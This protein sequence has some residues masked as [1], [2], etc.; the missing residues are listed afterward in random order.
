MNDDVLLAARDISFRQRRR[1]LLHG[2]E[3]VV[4]RGEIVTLIG[5]NGAGKTTLIRVL[6]GLERPD[7]GT[8][9]RRAGLRAGY[10]P[11]H[12]AVDA[13][14]PVTVRRFL[15]TG[16]AGAGREAGRYLA[17][18]GAADV[19]DRPLQRLSGGELRRVLLARALVCDPDLLVLDEPV[20]GVDVS[21]QLDMY[22]LVARLRDERGLGVLIVSHDLHLVMAAT[23]HVTCLSSGHV[24]CSG[25]PETVSRR[26]EYLNLFGEN[27]ASLLAIYRHHHDHRHD[28]AGHALPLDSSREE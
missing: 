14:L 23:D 4:R 9:E 8:V 25:H 20:A 1:E 27:A 10:V 15:E 28:L 16:R 24:C 2:V 3:L 7:A 12:F 11:Q 26:P 22:A 21:G 6:L 17:E 13:F 18:V 19:A 5:P